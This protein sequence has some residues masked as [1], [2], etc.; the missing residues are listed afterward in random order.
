MFWPSSD[1]PMLR[2]KGGSLEL[3]EFHGPTVEMPEAVLPKSQK[4]PTEKVREGAYTTTVE[5]DR[6]GR[7]TTIVVDDSGAGRDNTG[8]VSETSSVQKY[9]IDPKD[10]LSARAECVWTT[11]FS[12]EAWSTSVEGITIQ[13]CTAD[14]FIVESSLEMKHGDEVVLKR[15]WRHEIPRRNA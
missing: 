7:E 5:R 8:M 12:R 15:T 14:R 3:P 9:T 2:V 1:T 6:E 13:T 11:R 10:P 4:S